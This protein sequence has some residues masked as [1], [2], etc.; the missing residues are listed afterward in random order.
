MLQFQ[1]LI[2]MLLGCLIVA[3]DN[4]REGQEGGEM[5]REGGGGVVHEGGLFGVGVCAGWLV[6]GFRANK[7]DRNPEHRHPV[8][9]KKKKKSGPP[10]P[11]PAFSFKLVASWHD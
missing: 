10:P 2:D 11:P 4:H 8:L 9:Q 5:L 1:P 3:D 6:S 7:G